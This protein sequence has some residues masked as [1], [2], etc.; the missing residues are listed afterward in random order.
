ME[1][2]G[3]YLGL[4]MCRTDTHTDNGEAILVSSTIAATVVAWIT[5]IIGL[6][7]MSCGAP[8]EAQGQVRICGKRQTMRGPSSGHH[9]WRRVIKERRCTHNGDLTG[10]TE[11][12]TESKRAISP[13]SPM[14]PS[15]PQRSAREYDVCDESEGDNA[16]SY[17]NAVGGPPP[18][19]SGGIDCHNDESRDSSGNGILEMIKSYLASS[20]R[21]KEYYINIYI[22]I[23]MFYGG[24][25]WSLLCVSFGISCYIWQ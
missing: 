2:G 14:S 11:L 5:A 1:V 9:A 12:G 24:M 21:Q 6:V 13:P 16:V 8:L 17:Q 20:G 19:N 25:V 4:A 10:T 7:L 3:V 18:V 23:Y 22:Y 15:S